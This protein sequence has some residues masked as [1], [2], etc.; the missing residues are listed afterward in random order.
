MDKMAEL[1]KELAEK[2]GTSADKLGP[3]VVRHT[4][5]QATAE[6]VFG[7]V[8]VL[9]GLAGGIWLWHKWATDWKEGDLEAVPQGPVTI[10]GGIAIGLCVLIGSG[11]LVFWLPAAIEPIGA[12]LKALVGA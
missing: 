12:T 3:H 4:Q 6:C 10:L 8:L 7:A 2:L 9:L 1:L 5:I 11:I